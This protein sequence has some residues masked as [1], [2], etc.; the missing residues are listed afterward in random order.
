MTWETLES[1]EIKML[2]GHKVESV[3]AGPWKTI[4]WYHIQVIPAQNQT[5]FPPKGVLQKT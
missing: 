5:L 2:K 4:V 1:F 3:E